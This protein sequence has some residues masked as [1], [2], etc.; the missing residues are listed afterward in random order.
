MGNATQ[1]AALHTAAKKGE[2]ERLQH[3]LE[4]GTYDVNEGNDGKIPF[5]EEGVCPHTYTQREREKRKC[6]LTILL[7]IVCAASQWVCLV[8]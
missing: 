1:K 8:M 3:L 7:W 6:E 4:E 5:W 2:S